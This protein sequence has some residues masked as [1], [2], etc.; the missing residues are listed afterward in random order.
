MFKLTPNPSFWTKCSIT[1]PGQDKPATIELEWKHLSKEKIRD[2]FNDLDGKD[3]LDALSGVLLD[4]KGLDAEYSYDN[5]GELLNNYPASA[6]ELF[7][8]YRT[9]LLESR[10][11][12]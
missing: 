6:R 7:D 3:D 4:W 1:V 8:N 2:Y 11:K 9:N 5:L 12:T 10:K